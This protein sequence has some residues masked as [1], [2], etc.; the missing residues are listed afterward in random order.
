MLVY[1]NFIYH[2][3]QLILLNLLKMDYQ[4]NFNS[5]LLLLV[6]NPFIHILMNFH[7]L[8]VHLQHLI[9]LHLIQEEALIFKLYY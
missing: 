6:Q 7:L 8:L 5:F 4:P 1:L 3:F 2:L 9:K